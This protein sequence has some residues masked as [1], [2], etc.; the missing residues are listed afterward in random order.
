MNTYWS[1]V[2]QEMREVILYMLLIGIQKLTEIISTSI[3]PLHPLQP[4][5]DEH[6]LVLGGSQD[7]VVHHVM[8]CYSKDYSS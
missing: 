1:W 6:I 3:Q 8:R 7:E 4:I 2:G 5:M